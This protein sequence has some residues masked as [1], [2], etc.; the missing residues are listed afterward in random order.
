MATKYTL[1][2]SDTT[3]TPFDLQSYTTNGPESPSDDSIIA[4]ATTATTTL[5]LWGKGLKE[6][7]EPVF[8]DM[9]YMLENFAN[10]SA[11][12]FPIEGQLWYQPPTGGGSPVFT[13][14]RV[15]AYDG[16][17]WDTEFILT[18]GSSAMTEELILSG[19]PTSGVAAVPKQYVDSTF[20][21]PGHTHVTTEID[22]IIATF[23]EINSL[24]GIGSPVQT[25]F[26]GVQGQFT[27]VDTALDDKVSKV[28]P[29]T[30]MADGVNITFSLNGEILGLPAVPSGLTAATSQKYVDDQLAAGLGGDGVLSDVIWSNN[31]GGVGSPPIVTAETTLELTV[32]HPVNSPTTFI[33][34]GISRTGHTHAAIDIPIDNSFN[35]DYGNNVQTAI[36]KAEEEIELLKDG[37]IPPSATITVQRIFDILLSPLTVAGSPIDTFTTQN[38]LV[39]DNRISLTVNGVKQYAHARATQSILYTQVSTVSLTGLNP[40]LAYDFNIAIDG[41]APTTIS[42]NAGGS[43]FVDIS[44]HGA[45]AIVINDQLSA[46]DANFVIDSITSEIFKT[47]SSGTSSSIA[48]TDP[49]GSPNEYLFKAGSPALLT[50]LIEVST[51]VNG[52]EGDYTETNI[53]G[54]P[55]NSGGITSYVVFNYDIITGSKIESLLYV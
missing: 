20:S 43:P 24:V 8:Q 38:H 22:D 52:V 4:G 33:L 10:S 48:I 6:Y 15:H 31:T 26:D 51:A 27:A 40:L 45:L 55:V 18:N 12:V 30:I 37:G 25:Q 28:S 3:K 29:G 13:L 49:G 41:G 16:N 2:F 11:P 14:P 7:G 53:D 5:K 36:E 35:I 19:T 23:T 50:N 42:I 9:I 21:Q 47:T 1:Y 39:D 32:T 34:E 17:T 44:T 54:N 46:L